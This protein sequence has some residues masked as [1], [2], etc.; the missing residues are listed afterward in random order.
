[1]K[2]LIL[3]LFFGVAHAEYEAIKEW[4]EPLICYKL[5]SDGKR[6]KSV[7]LLWNNF[8]TFD[9]NGK[10]VFL[11]LNEGLHKVPTKGW[12]CVPESYEG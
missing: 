7:K 12:I 10:M 3:I 6:G 1:M 2:Y 4:E 11:K 5:D 9:E 8:L